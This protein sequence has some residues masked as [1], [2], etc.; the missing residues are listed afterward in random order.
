MGLDLRPSGRVIFL[1]EAV[2]SLG[3]DGGW[4]E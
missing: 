1:E 3:L 4:M 2:G